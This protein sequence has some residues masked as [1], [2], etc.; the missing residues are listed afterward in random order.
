[1]KEAKKYGLSDFQWV[2]VVI[3]A[4]LGAGITTLPRSVGEIA[5]RDGWISVLL[6]GAIAW[7]MAVIIWL[8][9]RRFPTRT[10]P[11]FSIMILG[12]PL[13]ILISVIY[14]LYAI[15]I[16][17]VALRIFVELAKTWTMIFTPMP[18]FVIAVLI[19]V[20]YIS[21]LGAVTLGRLMELMV[22]FTI[23]ILFVYLLPL[24]EFDLL[25]L[26]PVG[27]EG[28]RAILAAVPESAFSFLGF[29][30]MLVFFPFI[31]NRDKALRLTLIA[32]AIV[33]FLYA[34]NVIITYGV[35]GVE[36]AVV[37]IWPL[38]NYLRIGVLPFIQRVD[39]LV[40][41][42]WTAQV[43][44]V[45]AISYF[46][47]TFTLATLTRRR[48]HDIWAVAA[49]P[50]VYAVAILPERLSQAFDLGAAVAQWGLIGIIGGTALLL[51][52]AILRGLDESK[53]EKR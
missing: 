22:Y 5:G 16:G 49:S 10:L 30:V 48:Y 21:R 53:E 4:I 37:Q 1:M 42:V 29:E 9:C 13:G 27:A 50:L 44:A 12:R 7:L 41:F 33:T 11:E 17:A 18:V 34:G 51:L 43:M 35:L 39:N 26:R 38:M 47:S 24:G 45:V 40:I 8:L 31:I 36:H 20:V 46:A 6:A 23:A 52:V 3:C 15:G 2:S 28:W 14:A 32:L 25:N 19:P